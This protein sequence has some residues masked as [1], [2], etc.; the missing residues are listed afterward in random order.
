MSYRYID[1]IKIYLHIKVQL[2]CFAR[3]L[4]LNAI[5]AIQNRKFSI[6]SDQ[7]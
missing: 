3:G 4:K 2:I 7:W 5:I 6:W 1:F